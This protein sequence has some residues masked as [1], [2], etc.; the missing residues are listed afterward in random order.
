MALDVGQ[1]NQ[2]YLRAQDAVRREPGADLAAMQDSLRALVPADASEHDRTWTT[3]LIEELADPAEPERQWSALYD[4][5][6]RIHADAYR[7]TGSR[8]ERISA[9]ADARRRIW[10][11]ADRADEDEAPHIR[12]MTMTLEHLEQELRDSDWPVDSSEGDG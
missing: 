12:A 1:F 2:A 3:A 9:L 4:E 6:G 7:V 11:V 5:A 8:S 10:A